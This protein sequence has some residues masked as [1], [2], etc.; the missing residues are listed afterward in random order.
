MYF[1]MGRIFAFLPHLA[2]PFDC[3]FPPLLLLVYF[4]MLNIC[5]I[6]LVLSLFSFYLYSTF[7]I[8]DGFVHFHI[9]Q[10]IKQTDTPLSILTQVLGDNFF[11]DI[12]QDMVILF[13]RDNLVF[14]GAQ[15]P[16]V[17]EVRAF[18]GVQLL[19][20]SLRASDRRDRWDLIYGYDPVR[21]LFSRDRFEE[22]MA[23]IHIVDSRHADFNDS[24]RPMLDRL[25]SMF[26]ILFRST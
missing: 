7:C 5:I 10:K 4:F 12:F 8:C 6:F 24:L 17:D 13:Q 9:L 22:L 11:D 25:H 16:S 19:L 21:R 1:V 15:D 3:S 26:P 18:M 2:H 14:R 20:A 23:S